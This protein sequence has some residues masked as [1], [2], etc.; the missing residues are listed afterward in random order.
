MNNR[1]CCRGDSVAVYSYTDPAAMK[2]INVT[3]ACLF[4]FSSP[5][6][7]QVID[8]VRLGYAERDINSE[9]V[10]MAAT[11]DGRFIGFVYKDNTIKILDVTSGKTAKLFK[12]PYSD[13]LDFF[14]T[15]G[16]VA[17][18]IRKSEV[19]LIDWKKEQTLLKLALKNDATKA[20]Y[21]GASDILAIGQ[22]E[23]YVSLV[24]VSNRRMLHDLQVKKHHVS[25]LAFHPD[26]NSIA[27]AV[28]AALNFNPAPVTLFDV[29][30]GQQKTASIEEAYFTMLAFNEN[31]TEILAAGMKR[32][33]T[34]RV[35]F[36]LDAQTLLTKREYAAESTLNTTKTLY[37]GTI[38]GKKL[39]GVTYSHSFNVYDATNGGMEFTTGS[40][41]GGLPAFIF[42]G[43]GSYNVFPLGPGSGKVILNATKNNIN[44][45]Y[46]VT[47]NSIVGYVFSDSNDDFAVV[48][49]DG[50]VD[51][52]ESALSK[53]YWSS[54]KSLRK[55]SLEST[56]EKGFTP[57]LLSSIISGNT[58]DV[59]F[60]IDD[61]VG[62]IPVVTLKSV[63]ASPARELN[64]LQSSQK[65]SK[66]EILATENTGEI[67]EVKLFH[68]NKLIQTIP[69]T[70]NAVFQF[71]VTLNNAYG[72]QNF[73]YVTASSKS[74]I[75]SEKLKFVINYKGVTTEEPNLYLITI[76]IDE[77]RNAKYNLNYAQADADGVAEAIR[78]R[79]SSLFKNVYNF[80][81]RN[82][83]A[84]KTGILD[85]FDQVK[86]KALEQDVL[87]VYYAGHG[88][89]SEESPGKPREFFLIPHDITQ[90]YGRDEMLFEKAI[91]AEEIK[92][93]TKTINAQK[94]IF[95]L[96]ACQ[97]A[98]ALQTVSRGALEE[99]AIAH[100]AR[101]TGTFWI[102][103]SG[104]EQFASEFEQ[105]KHGVFTYAL[106]EGLGGKA[107]A[108]ADR[109]LTVRELSTYIEQV[110]PE[111][112][113]RFKG[114]A[115]FPSAYSFGNDFPI[116][117]Y[118]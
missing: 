67:I 10:A 40:E 38:F 114:V 34:K 96:D 80:Q 87:I 82:D 15:T 48:S 52:T 90:L 108:N 73:F 29:K 111:L 110:V 99:K 75:D 59:A 103:A 26:G 1:S 18:L 44:Q 78:T 91:S 71:D 89:M 19:V 85:A 107:D 79:S 95:I 118:K 43:V 12:G 76:G 56:F 81:L 45:I 105:L 51:G 35:M 33:A 16:G 37:G 17:A 102:T 6:F 86:Q 13:V 23:G 55:T 7:P 63:N 88:V 98:G 77:Y 57:N 61:V 39:L 21:S 93:I 36:S 4:L 92:A 46:D 112:S 42:W 8:V 20:V 3:L 83:K 74:R 54:R 94:Q 84:L 27:V 60:E 115:Q 113:E 25:A 41:R 9:Q 65:A 100:M 30:S 14:L 2:V 104:S 68:N 69:N 11:P 117:V 28:V 72:D 101:S 109:K 50:K 66:I 5:C 58:Y 31:G 47:T 62:K 49:R 116:V 24:D 97:S 106:L 22:Q 64:N 70:G 53:L 32:N